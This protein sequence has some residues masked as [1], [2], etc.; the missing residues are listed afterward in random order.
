MSFQSFINNPKAY[1]KVHEMQLQGAGAN[2]VPASV[3]RAAPVVNPAHGNSIQFTHIANVQMALSQSV[4]AKNFAAMAL[5]R[6]GV[7]NK[8]GITYVPAVG[9]AFP[10]LRIL[11]WSGTDVTFMQL[12]GGADFALTGP[13]TG[14]TVSV[15]R[16]AGNLWFFHANV[17]GG[18]GMG[19]ANR[20]TKRSMIRH[21][22][23]LVGV[24]Q[25]ANYFFCEYGP[26][27]QY[28][29]LGF[30]W[31]RLRAGGVWKFYVH[32]IQPPNPGALLNTNTTSDGKWAQL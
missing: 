5:G 3:T 32:E 29:G 21:A 19:P 25:T 30:V 17:A 24:P 23:S 14:C 6:A 28:E 16:H 13:L 12:D 22:G 11:P 31:G 9:G 20:A 15:V 10:N 7:M 4:G 26:Q 18:G 2:L 1:V 8:R 27:H